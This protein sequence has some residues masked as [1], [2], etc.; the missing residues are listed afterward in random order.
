MDF[1]LLNDYLVKISFFFIYNI[2]SDLQLALAS[3]ME[4]FYYYFCS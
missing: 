2:S 4:Y 1:F 3:V